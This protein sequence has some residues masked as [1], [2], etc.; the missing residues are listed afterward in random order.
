MEINCI[1][2]F[3]YTFKIFFWSVATLSPQ[4]GAM[5][6]RG[7]LWEKYCPQHWS[8]SCHRPPNSPPDELHLT[9]KTCTGSLLV[10]LFCFRDIQPLMINRLNGYEWRDCTLRA[11]FT[12]LR[13]SDIRDLCCDCRAACEPRIQQQGRL[14]SWVACVTADAASR[15]PYFR[16]KSLARVN[17]I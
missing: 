4:G 6:A 14:R 9:N 11:M 8:G 16:E 1:E 10:H 12:T 5:A 17:L 3:L 13:R 7:I 15:L 2:Y